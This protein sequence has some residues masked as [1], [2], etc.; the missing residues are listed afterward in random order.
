MV[1]FGGWDMPVQYSGIIQEHNATRQDAGLFDVS[2]MGEIFIEG[3][4]ESILDFLEKTTCNTIETMKNGQVQ[5]NAVLNETGGLVDDVT[6]YKFNDLDGIGLSGRLEII[7]DTRDEAGF[8]EVNNS[9][10]RI[11]LS[12]DPE[13][14]I[15]YETGKPGHSQDGIIEP[16]GQ[17]QGLSVQLAVFA[18]LPSETGGKPSASTFYEFNECFECP[19]PHNPNIKEYFI[20][21]NGT[22]PLTGLPFEFDYGVDF[23]E[24]TAIPEP[25]IFVLSVIGSFVLACINRRRKRLR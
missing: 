1:P 5:Y 12:I 10:V 21:T 8:I 14:G 6:I 16:F 7:D 13:F 19:Q 23:V 15:A 24:I 9:S 25:S 22:D 3:E 4:K 18:V 17:G 11:S 20:Y 2:H